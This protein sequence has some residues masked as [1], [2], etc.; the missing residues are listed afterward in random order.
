MYESGEELTDC[1]AANGTSTEGPHCYFGRRRRSCLYPPFRV[2]AHRPS[3][4]ELL[5]QEKDLLNVY[6]KCREDAYLKNTHHHREHAK[7]AKHAEP[8]AQESGYN[9]LNVR[10]LFHSLLTEPPN[11]QLPASL[12]YEADAVPTNSARGSWCG[13]PA[14]YKP[15][16]QPCPLSVISDFPSYDVYE[17]TIHKAALGAGTDGHATVT[18]NENEAADGGDAAKSSRSVSSAPLGLF[19]VDGDEAARHRQLQ[20]VDLQALLC[21]CLCAVKFAANERQG[22]AGEGPLADGGGV[23]DVGSGRSP[24]IALPLLVAASMVGCASLPERD[25]VVPSELGPPSD[26][27]PQYQNLE[28]LRAGGVRQSWAAGHGLAREGGPFSPE[29]IREL[30]QVRRSLCRFD[31][32]HGRYVAAQSKRS[33][34]GQRP[35]ATGLSSQPPTLSSEDIGGGLDQAR[36]AQLA[37]QKP[38]CEADSLLL[39]QNEDEH[40]THV[41]T[42]LMRQVIQF[43]GHLETELRILVLR[44][45]S[46]VK[47]MLRADSGSRHF[48]LRLEEHIR[49]VL[50][51]HFSCAGK[52]PPREGPTDSI[53]LLVG[54]ALSCEGTVTVPPCA[55][56]VSQRRVAGQYPSSIIV[57]DALPVFRKMAHS[58]CGLYGLKSFSTSE[59]SPSCA[60]SGCPSAATSLISDPT[61][62]A[63]LAAQKHFKDLDPIPPPAPPPVVTARPWPKG[64][65]AAAAIA[66]EVRG[67]R[68]TFKGKGACPPPC[69]ES[70]SGNLTPVANA[71]GKASGLRCTGAKDFNVFECPAGGGQVDKDRARPAGQGSWSSPLQDSTRTVPGNRCRVGLTWRCSCQ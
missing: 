17:P 52:L 23:N 32:T 62:P 61:A 27:N 65:G 44:T 29:L 42:A 64:E 40:W 45:F 11:G 33:H 35:E 48:L 60:P 26:A 13:S 9:G 66:A 3:V 57:W 6:L 1:E 28:P 67:E 14:G 71:G 5:L 41:A 49:Q 70:Q 47:K 36:P 54:D 55:Y 25:N 16:A 20:T 38:Q 58:L 69:H 24:R 68:G 63:E 51:F 34:E 8:T 53:V 2:P 59:D 18:R 22:K 37:E 19:H 39:L 50:S 30:D 46:P 15:P 43:L 31:R 21:S 10:R 7:R 12:H 56:S 4:W